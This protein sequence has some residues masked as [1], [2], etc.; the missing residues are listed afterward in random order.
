[1][2]LSCDSISL[3]CVTD[4][5]AGAS[6]AFLSA[7]STPTSDFFV[8]EFLVNA[9]PKI[10]HDTVAGQSRVASDAPPRKDAEVFRTEAGSHSDEIA[11]VRNLR[12]THFRRWDTEIVV[13]GDGGMSRKQPSFA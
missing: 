5:S 13:G 6:C 1:M 11:Q 9:G 3:N 10:F 8:R 7:N 2:I 4:E 12:F